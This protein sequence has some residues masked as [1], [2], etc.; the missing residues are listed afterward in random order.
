MAAHSSILAWEIP[1]TEE[2]P[3]H[4]EQLH[5]LLGSYGSQGIDQ[6][7]FGGHRGNRGQS[8]PTSHCPETIRQTV[9]GVKKQITHI[10]RCLYEQ[11]SS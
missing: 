11:T 2:S 10:R 9:A 5:R 8:L 3:G 7:L 4:S 1:W 6:M